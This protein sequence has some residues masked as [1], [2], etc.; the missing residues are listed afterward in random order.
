MVWSRQYGR[1]IL[2][3]VVQSTHCIHVK[4]WWFSFS[5]KG[6]GEMNS[7]ITTAAVKSVNAQNESLQRMYKTGSYQVQHMWFLGTT[8]PPLRSMQRLVEKP[9]VQVLYCTITF[10]PMNPKSDSIKFPLV[11]S[12]LYKTEWSWEL[13]TGSHK[14]NYFA[15]H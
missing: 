10:N 2:G 14:I 4:Q 3:N 5:W 7:G 13:R 1:I 12:M 11:T 6:K 9:E 15:W 8:H